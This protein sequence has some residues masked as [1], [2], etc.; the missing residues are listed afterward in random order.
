MLLFVTCD[1][2]AGINQF[3]CSS[4]QMD[5]DCHSYNGDW[6]NDNYYCCEGD[7]LLISLYNSTG[8]RPKL[9]PYFLKYLEK[10]NLIRK[11]CHILFS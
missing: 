6:T 3:D 7:T 10:F 2:N 5:R 1:E 11:C 9:L 8:S 4:F